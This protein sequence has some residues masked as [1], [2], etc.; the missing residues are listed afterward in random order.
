MSLLPWATLHSDSEHLPTK[1]KNLK[2]KFESPRPTSP[3]I[4]GI[5]LVALVRDN[6]G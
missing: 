6:G 1:S 4:L 2:Y 3:G 5:D